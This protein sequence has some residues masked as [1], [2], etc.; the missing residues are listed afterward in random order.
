MR[1][2]NRAERGGRYHIYLGEPQGPAGAAWLRPHVRA[3]LRPHDWLELPAN[4]LSD[5]GL[6]S[7]AR[8]SAG[9]MGERPGDVGVYSASTSCRRC[10]PRLHQS[11][12]SR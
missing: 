7:E 2:C 3:G 1:S 8:G 4:W 6:P 12:S 10:V 11:C 9:G 5:T